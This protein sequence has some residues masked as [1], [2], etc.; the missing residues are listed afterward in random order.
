[1]YITIIPG[2]AIVGFGLSFVTFGVSLGL[3]IPGAALACLGGATIAGAEIGYLAVSKT[4]LKDAN[5]AYK[6]DIELVMEFKELREKFCKQLDSLAKKHNSTREKILAFVLHGWNSKSAGRAFYST[7]KTIDGIFEVGKA[8]GSWIKF[9]GV[10]GRTV[11]SA[12][13]TVTRVIGVVG[14]AFDV[15]SIPIDLG[16]MLKSAY[17]VHKYKT[18]GESNSNVAKE[19]GQLIKDL[20][21]NRDEL[22]KHSDEL[23]T[24]V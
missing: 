2:I 4:K 23:G 19:I 20:E 7:Y 14:V 3:L 1:M 15:V 5:S 16:V 11:W 17:D 10:A 21:K 6:A 22:Q 24:V 18:K 12:A 8:F 9:G 13:S